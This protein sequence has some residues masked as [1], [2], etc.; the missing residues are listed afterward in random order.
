MKKIFYVF[1]F[2]YIFDYSVAQPYRYEIT[3]D[4][5]NSFYIEFSRDTIN[6]RYGVLVANLFYKK[7]NNTPELVYSHKGGMSLKE[8]EKGEKLFYEV[9][10]IYYE[11]DF[12]SLS[13]H[14][15]PSGYSGYFSLLFFEKRNGKWEYIT[16]NDEDSNINTMIKGYQFHSDISGLDYPMRGR[17][18]DSK[19]YECDYIH[20]SCTYI[21][22][23]KD[24]S[25]INARK[26]EH[27]YS[28]LQKELDRKQ[29][30][31]KEKIKALNLVSLIKN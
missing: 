9:E 7:E 15:R 17:F 4:K 5:Q 30:I 28:Y 8:I 10:D 24:I 20:S 2:I 29:E 26:S 14:F 21:L 16:L 3:N 11:K 1:V 22:K 12:I 6:A 27:E 25:I 23:D 18:I 13:V 31:K 19:T